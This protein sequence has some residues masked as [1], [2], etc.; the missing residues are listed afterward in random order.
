MKL[1][2]N[3]PMLGMAAAFIAL[4]APGSVP[5]ADRTVGSE[6][7][8]EGSSLG[9]WVAVG[10]RTDAAL[11]QPKRMLHRADTEAARDSVEL[12]GAEVPTVATGRRTDTV[13]KQPWQARDAAETRAEFA[14][15]EEARPVSRFATPQ[16][17][18]DGGR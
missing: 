14:G 5:A 15:L 16:R 3:W 13:M 18:M 10:R 1:K 6:A 7:A 11:R 9:P 2:T 4:L 17:P 12:P 8:N